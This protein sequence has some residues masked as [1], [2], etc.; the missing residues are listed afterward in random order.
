MGQGEVLLDVEVQTSEQMEE[1]G[2]QVAGWLSAGDVLLLNGPLGA[3]KTTFTRG[4]GA[5]LGV[6]GAVTSPTFVI[7]RVHPGP[8][9][10]VHV[11][12]YRLGSYAE[13]DDLDLEHDLADTVTVIEWGG[14]VAEG[15]ASRRLDVTIERSIG[16]EVPAS[17]DAN[18]EDTDP[19]H[20]TITAIGGFTPAS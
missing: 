6:R 4:L 7:A 15:L 19:R 5:A 10:L 16:N 11:D 17:P 9:P 13:L 20:V 1:L 14:G 12:A 18:V 3:G 8:L 2:A